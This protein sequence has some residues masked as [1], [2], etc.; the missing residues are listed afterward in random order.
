LSYSLVLG[1][2]YE[3][4]G[5][6]MERLDIVEKRVEVLEQNYSMLKQDITAVQNGQLQLENTVLKGNKDQSDLLNKLV[7]HTLDIK[8]T[9]VLARKDIIIAVLS[10]GSVVGLVLGAVINFF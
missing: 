1:G 9:K 4:E 2:G 8:K 7:D 10:G 5:S 3:L 6:Q